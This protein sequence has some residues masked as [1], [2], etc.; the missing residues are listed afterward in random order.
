MC[1]L[2]FIHCLFDVLIGSVRIFLPP[3][4]A[5]S[6]IKL[7]KPGYVKYKHS[8]YYL[9]SQEENNSNNAA[10]SIVLYFNAFKDYT[11]SAFTIDK[12]T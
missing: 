6:K 9:C 7:S 4:K 2:L 8:L 5:Q 1:V 11:I 3:C 10:Q 12:L